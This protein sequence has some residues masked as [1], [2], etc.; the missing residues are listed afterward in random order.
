MHRLF[1]ALRPPL[2]MREALLAAMGDI[3]GARWQDDAQFHLTLRF[4]GEV[5]RHVAEDIAAALG[6]VSHPAFALRLDGVGCFDRRGRIDNIW[7]GVTPHQPVKSLHAAVTAALVRAGI[8]PEERAFVPHITLA[9]FARG[10][11]PSGTLP[12]DSLWPAPVEGRFD[13]FLLYE[14]HL[15]ASGA[16]YSAIARYRLG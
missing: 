14:S 2:P 5:D 10:Q 13:H 1:I 16:S 9:R 3:P 7:A 15:G 6:A 11:A 8:A 4:V 12:M